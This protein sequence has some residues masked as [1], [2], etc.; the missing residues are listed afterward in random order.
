M[1][2]S[3]PSATREVFPRGNDHH[4]GDILT[5]PDG[6]RTAGHFDRQRH[7]P[8]VR[9]SYRHRHLHVSRRA[10][11]HRTARRRHGQRYHQ[12]HG[13]RPDHRHRALQRRRPI[14]SFER[15]DHTARF[16]GVDDYDGE[17]VSDPSVFG[18]TVTLTAQVAAAAP[19]SG[20]P[21]GT[22]TFVINGGGGGTLTAPLVGGTA[23]VTTNSLSVG[24]HNVT[25]TYNGDVNFNGSSGTDTQTVQNKASTTT[26]VSSS[27][28]P[29][30]FG[31][32]VTFTAHVGAVPPGV[33]T[34]TGTVTFLIDGGGGGTLTGTL[35]GGTATV[36]T[37]S[38]SVGGH[39]VT[40]TYNG[41]VNF[42]TSVGSDTQLVNQAS[43]TTTVSSSPDP[44]VWG[45]P[46]TFTATVAP[47]SPGAGTPSGTVTFVISGGP[48][49]TGNLVGGTATV[50]TS[51]LG[52]GSHTVTATY[53]GSVNFAGSSGSDTQ[54]VN[55]ASTSTTVTTSPDPSLAGQPVT[56]TATVTADSPGAGIA[57]GNVNFVI[58]GGVPVPATLSGGTASITTS[59]LSAGS[60]TIT[61]TYG[62]DA[63][64][65]GSSGSDTQLVNQAST[66]TTVSSSPDPS[67]WGQPVTFTATVAPVSP[68][69]GT[70]SGTVTFVISGGPT[71]TGNLVGGTAT[72]TTSTLG[73]GSHTVTATYNGSADYAGSSGSDTQ[74]VNQAATSTTVS[75]SPDPSVSGQSVTFTALVAPVAP[76]SGLPTGTVNFSVTNGVITLNFSGSL[77][78]SGTAAVSTE[79]GSG[80]YTVTATY[81]G[82]ANFTGSSGSDTQL[83]DQ[84]S[85]TTL[86]S[87]SPDPSVWGQS[88]TFTATVAPVLPGVGT[89]SGTVTFVIS[90]G[91][92]LTGNLVG[93]TATVTTSVLGVGS[94]TVTATYGGD[95]NFTGSS[96]SDTQLVDQ[97]SST[98]LVS[99]SPD[100]S[101]WG[102]SV[103]F[104]ATVAPV[105]PG[106]GTPSGTVT[107]VISGGPTLT[108][109]LVGGTATVTTSVLGVG[110][111]NVT[112]TYNG[113]VNF[114]G[115]SGSDTQVVNQAATTTVVVSSPDPSVS[116]ELVTF[117]AT[118][119]ADSPGSGSPSGN[120]NFVID[121]GVPV[122]A[123]LSGGTAS[124]TTSTL[125]VGS[126]S[127]T[128]TYGGDAD[129]TGSSDTDT[130]VVNQ[131][132]TTTVVV[133]SP[134][135]S[136]SG[137]L[138][139]FTATVTADSPGSG[140]LTGNVNFV[141]DGGAPLSATLSGGV[142]TVT[143]ST[144]SVGSHNVTATYNGDVN[145]AGSSGTD[146]QLVNQ[147]ATTTT[148]VSSPDPSVSGEL[149]T[150]T[151]TVTA[152]SPGSGTLTGN[153]NFVIDGGVPVPATLSGGTASIT[154]STLSVG[155]HAITATYGGD[156]NFT[157]SSGSD[158]QVVNQAAT[159]TVVVSSPDPSVSGELVTFTAT[160]TADSP[161][162]GTPTG[163]VN[164]VIDG[165]VP[166]PA[167]LSGGTASFTTS[168]LSVGGHSVT[169][170]YGGDADFTGSSGTDTQVVSQ[171]A[172]TTTVVSAPDPSVSGE[173]VTF[174]I[175]VA[176]DSPGSG[177]PTGNVTLVID[178]GAPLSAV[179]SG[180]V[181]TVTTSTLSVGSHSVTAT[182][183]GDADF[184]GSSGTDTQVVSQAATTTTV[185]SAPDPSVSGELVTFTIN[186]AADSPGSGTPTGNVTYQIDGGA[187]LSAVLSGGV[188]TVT[189]STL[190][191]GGHSVTA[192]YGGDA[193]FTGSSGSDTQVVNQASTTTALVSAP[194]PS[195]SGE[196]VTFTATVTANSP[197]SG[198][199]TGNVNFVIDGG[200]PLSAALSGGVAT[201][202]TGTLSVGSHSV[203]ATYGGDADFTGSSGTDTQVVSQAA[204][205]TTVV[206]APDP[207]VSG[208]LVTF[209]INVAVDSP[210]SGTP[211]GN[212]TLVIDGGA[213]LS[214]ALSGG[215]ATV[216][217]GTLSVGSH[218]VTATYGG[219]ADFTGSSGTD[220]QVVSQAATTTTVV[221]APDPSVSGELVTFTI[222]VA[223][224]SP[225]SGTPT[226][227]V[228]LV[229]D[230][231]APL[232]A[233][234]SGGVATVT[235]GTLSVGSHSV[236]ATYGGD[237]DF[238]GSSGT[239]T[240]VVSQ[241][242]T[243]T[244]VVSAPDPSVSGELVTFTINVAVDSPGS[245]TPTGNVTL[246]IDGGAPLSAALSGGVA[247]VT[248]GTLSVGSHS[249]TATYGGDADFTG[250]SGTDTQVVNQ[251]ATTTT[252]TTFP[253]PST[254]GQTVNFVTFVGS[255]APGAGVPTGTVDFVITDGVTT[256]NLSGNL[257]TNGVAAV[258]SA[259]IDPGTYNVTA[260]YLGDLD[261]IGSSDTD[262][263]TVL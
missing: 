56:I 112:A 224:D 77:D 203:T 64:F 159:T 250:S 212:V 233:A 146:T 177:T 162:S 226:G 228:T 108:G 220:T 93:G 229:I 14:Q 134:D 209:T 202:T 70:P 179:L 94:H 119:T 196:L 232:S 223:V 155:S 151:A 237:A 4:P 188:A 241:A 214:A 106:V 95:A 215:V 200:A 234:L 247:T 45:Q 68:G 127:V 83:V 31:Q 208:E 100:P 217:T 73:V 5:E 96:G 48:T 35:V 171:A 105:L 130:Q 251:A 193:D 2:G 195:V 245:G 145:F 80:N 150:F 132:A 19:G 219:D 12:R 173:L 11:A 144:L 117:T 197:G 65:T 9:D 88:V 37:N 137:E 157:G 42:N 198:S 194:D 84:A 201:V 187:P 216:T 242:A 110:S 174:T 182:Y 89:P 22:V 225:G 178:G 58:D 192:T 38:L 97:A 183:G 263:Q 206:S 191:V 185:V 246:V 52:V 230:G 244:T 181:A 6:R 20:T 103:T 138:V 211:T 140:T 87:S 156:A 13:R 184:T 74:L 168:T 172:T 175:N 3:P 116:G 252:L 121:G 61:A 72:V 222:N 63:N 39:N 257:D 115:S 253:D 60:H 236:T 62:G 218:S 33:G 189:T 46:V 82:D 210:G 165:G 34:P 170:T 47:V 141:I 16:Q 86:V 239:D 107:F 186:V 128:A 69:A 169:A 25:A 101:V 227:N 90:G 79:L 161:G 32:T 125:S 152:N 28:D 160:V 30:V 55:Q 36:T 114:A 256:V 8:L 18:Q 92:T 158:M 120:V 139:T 10:H 213:P 23:T 243:T 81:G 133:S 17:L 249:V 57:T 71:L 259:L 255:V 154:T 27:P 53:N 231:G 135:P 21:T 59:T 1:G 76:G 113:D 7:P 166:V 163:N 124:I 102:Q 44:S 122:P 78:G 149:V 235:T 104:T 91:P 258:S 260:T 118:V 148:V 142:A 15:E 26:T 24:G 49:L 129:F 238:T 85:S 109:N 248:T 176:A 254:S 29:S 50:T 167:T 66:T 240:Q 205:T 43:T 153:V 67:V 180:G 136:V 221:S 207:S 190:S 143:T 164:F 123:T 199:P 147:A 40:A 262:T 51:V 204:T 261:Y 98:T 54:L 111:H 75:S 41:D 99:S 131:A 126:H